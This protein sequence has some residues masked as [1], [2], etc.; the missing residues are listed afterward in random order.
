MDNYTLAGEEGLVCLTSCPIGYLAHL[1][2][3]LCGN[4]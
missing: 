2:A 1:P 3:I 4:F